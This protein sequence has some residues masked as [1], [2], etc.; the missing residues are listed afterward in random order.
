[1]QKHDELGLPAYFESDRIQVEGLVVQ[2]YSS[3][4][5][6]WNAASSLGA[7]LKESGTPGIAGVDTRL[8]TKRI[9]ESGALLG[10]IIID[11]G[12]PIAKGPFVDPNRRNLV[13][14][15]SART[16]RVYGAG[17]KTRV[18]AVDCGIKVNMI[19]MLVARGCEV[20]VVPWD[21]DIASER[22]W[23]DALFISNGP[24]DP[25]KCT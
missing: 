16:P 10:K 19:R 23:Y 4:Y 2:D 7:W 6:H 9:R 13:A 21:W 15:V 24:G 25:E 8:L 14:E 12:S 17:N 5:S 20:K 18:L 1:M 11:G 22:A 3:H